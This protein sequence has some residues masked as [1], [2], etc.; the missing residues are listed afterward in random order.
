LACGLLAATLGSASATRAAGHT[1]LA[2]NFE[3]VVAGGGSRLTVVAGDQVTWS[4]S[5]N[6]HTVTSGAPGA[7]DDRFDDRPASAGLLLDGDAFTTTFAQAG[8]YPYFC[9]VHPEQMTGVVAVVAASTPAPT[10]APTSTP[11]SAPTSTPTSAPTP[12]P[13]PAATP[14]ATPAPTPAPTPG[15]TVAS[16]DGTPAGAPSPTIRTT[17]QP[18]ARSTLAA[19][20]STSARPM[21]SS[22]AEAAASPA[23]SGTAS[24]A[25]G[26]P[27]VADGSASGPPFALLAIGGAVA[28]AGLLA[29]SRRRPGG[30]A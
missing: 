26:V 20:P 6:P 21:P 7:I 17:Q 27:A 8:T 5:G 1:V 16:P 29:I 23:T 30:G 12:K 10:S 13:T 19:E 4:A 9:E 14:R 28:L 3:F 18:S 15:P 2:R 22:S 24:G 25:P 11:T